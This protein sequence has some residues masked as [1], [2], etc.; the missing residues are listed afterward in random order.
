MKWV[1]FLNSFGKNWSGVAPEPVKSPPTQNAFNWCSKRLEMRKIYFQTEIKLTYEVVF[2]TI[3]PISSNSKNVFLWLV[4]FFSVRFTVPGSDG[5]FSI[6]PWV[7]PNVGI[8]S[9]PMIANQTAATARNVIITSQSKPTY[10]YDNYN[11]NYDLV[12]MDKTYPRVICSN[13]TSSRSPVSA[14][15]IKRMLW[16]AKKVNLFWSN[17][18]RPAASASAATSAGAS[19]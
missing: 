19:S 14:Y 10:T 1:H 3:K 4:S 16:L 12:S 9:C 7:C 11:N 18:D 5:A 8:I 15:A 17:R 2:P 13:K 6:E